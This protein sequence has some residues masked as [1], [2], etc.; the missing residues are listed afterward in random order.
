MNNIQDP[1]THLVKEF[2]NVLFDKDEYTCFADSTKETQIQSV[3]RQGVKTDKQYFSINPIIKGKTRSKHNVSQFRNILVEIDKDPDGNHIPREI[4]KKMFSK[5]GIPYATLVWSAGKSLH[6]IISLEEPFEDIVEYNQAVQAVYRVLQK[7]K[8]WNDESVKDA[9]RFS[10]AAGALR[11]GTREFQPVEQVKNRITR[12]EFD[13]WLERYGEEV[14]EIKYHEGNIEYKGTST[15]DNDLKWDWVLKYYM[16]NDDYVQG[17]RH[18]YQVKMAYCLARTGMSADDITHYFNQKFGEVS[19]GIHNMETLIKEANGEAIYVPTMEER[20]KYMKELEAKD[21]ISNAVD[22]VV[23]WN[24][25]ADVKVRG[26]A[27]CEYVLVGN[28]F[29]WVD[30]QTNIRRKRNIQAIRTRFP[31]IKL[32]ELV[33]ADRTYTSFDYFP[34]YH[35][36]Q[37]RVNNC[38]NT[39]EPFMFE[40]SIGKWPDIEKHLKHLFGKESDDPTDYQNQYYEIIEWFRVAVNDPTHPLWGIVLTSQAHGVGKNI[41]AI[42]CKAIF[43]INYKQIRRSDVENERFNGA[44]GES[45][46]C[47]IDEFEKVKDPIRAYGM[48]KEMITATEGIRIERKGEESYEIPFY[49]KFVF[50]HNAA[51]VGFPGIESQDRR[52]WLREIYKPNFVMDDA[53]VKRIKQQIPHFVYDLLYVI[54]PR[55]EQG[56][57]K[58]QGALWIPAE[59]T[60]TIWLENSKEH[61]KSTYYHKLKSE[62]DAFFQDSDQDVVYTTARSL[63]QKLKIDEERAI[64]SCLLDEFGAKQ[65][66]KTVRR[67]NFI[68]DKK[69]KNGTKYFHITREMVYGKEE[70][71]M[72]FSEDIFKI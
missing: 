14:G 54:E 15:A 45:Q 72:L 42:I 4:Q 48:F 52:I 47:F 66:E 68:E 57:T 6:G 22:E 60:W 31:G 39:H 62:F 38:Y 30:P 8:I 40:P 32:H 56:V 43:G 18:H 21:T 35:N 29:Y 70:E 33:T 20:R 36:Y 44:F 23:N 24:A 16:K 19:T 50:A 67:Y 12:Q 5:I 34:D 41:F 46:I 28:D 65:D 58:N 49:G 64:T 26:E 55:Y 13:D 9:A 51:R 11:I 53:Y 59:N 37:R 1:N 61:N 2:Y 7:N 25:V 10:R 69:P 27:P 3:S 63:A 71:S 17:K